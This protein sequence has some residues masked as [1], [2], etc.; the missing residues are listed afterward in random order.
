MNRLIFLPLF[1]FLMGVAVWPQMRTLS[2]GTE[3]KVRT[4][5]PIPA[6][7]TTGARFTATVSNDVPS[8]S[9]GVAIPKG[10]RASLVASPHK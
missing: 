5:M 7:P 3:I 10:S 6:H 8:A 4:D 1:V 9:G 2:E